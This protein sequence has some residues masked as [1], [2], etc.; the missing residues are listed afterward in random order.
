MEK[1]FT[2]K[3]QYEKKSDERRGLRKLT[4]A[5]GDRIERNKVIHL[6]VE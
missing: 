5:T 2:D 6:G 4:D 1:R 3:R